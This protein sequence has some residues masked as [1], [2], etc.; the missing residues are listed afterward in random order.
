MANTAAHAG[1]RTAPARFHRWMTGAHLWILVGL[2]LDGYYHIH[3]PGL[4]TFLTP[5]HGVLYSGVGVT[6]ALIVEQTLRNRRAGA[7]FR[8]AIPDGYALAAIG[9]LIVLA[10]GAVDAVW[11]AVLGIE[12]G[13]EALLSPPHLTMAVAGILVATGPLRAL[14]RQPSRVAARQAPRGAAGIWP[15]VIAV[16]LALSLLGFF[17][18]FANPMTHRFA[19]AAGEAAAGQVDLVHAAGIVGYVLWGAILA[20]GVLLLAVRWRLPIGAITVVVAIPSAFLATQRGTYLLL[21]AAILAGVLGDALAARRPPSPEDRRAMR[22]VGAAVPAAVTAGSLLTAA[23]LGDLG[24]SIHLTT[25]AVVVSAA[26]G[27]FI[28]VLVAPPAVPSADTAPDEP[29][30]PALPAS[31]PE[32]TAAR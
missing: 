2:Y 1:P 11:H 26:A 10:G 12:V 25:G 24:W 27:L 20:G 17:T 21:P 13:V 15:A 18:Q 4:E 28:S 6:V 23:V 7:G 9:G 3:E 8:E 31:R 29:A 16:G 19:T 32:A 22:I 30:V 5:W 14:W